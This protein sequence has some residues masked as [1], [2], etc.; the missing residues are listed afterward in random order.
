MHVEEIT[1]EQIAAEQEIVALAVEAAVA[2]RMPGQ[3]HHAQA[4]HQ[5]DGGEQGNGQSS[6]DGSPETNSSS[7]RPAE[8]VADQVDE[9]GRR[10]IGNR[11]AEVAEAL[12]KHR[13]PPRARPAAAPWRATA[14]T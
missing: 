6:A 14:W 8:R 3:I 2:E 12:V 5:Q 4:A 13:Q 1:R 11:G 7:C 10:R 9:W